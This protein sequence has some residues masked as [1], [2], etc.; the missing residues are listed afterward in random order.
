MLRTLTTAVAALSVAAIPAI[1]QMADR[2]DLIRARDITGGPIYSVA[3]IYDEATWLDAESPAYGYESVGY[4]MDYRQIG[5]IED[6]VL[7]S[8]GQVIGIV[9]EIGGFLDIGD[10]HVMLPTEDLRLVAVDDRSYTYVTRFTEEQLE[11]MEGVDEGFW[12]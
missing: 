9:A 1:A 5:E 10:K 4:G 3:P 11:E 12:N 2:G 7:D 8:G 6:L